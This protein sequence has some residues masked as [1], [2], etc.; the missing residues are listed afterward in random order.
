[1]LSTPLTKYDELLTDLRNSDVS[2]FL[3]Y[4]KS[5]L[6]NLKKIL[7]EKKILILPVNFVFL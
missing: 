4:L 2:N 7:L 6:I 3:K 1:M 5:K